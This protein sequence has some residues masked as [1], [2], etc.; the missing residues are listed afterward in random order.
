VQKIIISRTDSIGD[1]VLTMP[2]VGKLKEMIPACSIVFL[3][4]DYT[5]DIVSMSVFVDE[6][7]SWD[8]LLK[9]KSK[10]ERISALKN[11]QAD[12]IIHVFPRKEIAYLAKSAGIQNRIGTS[13]RLYHYLTCNQLVRFSR[14]RSDLHEAQ[15]NFKLLKPLGYNHTISLQEIE[16][17]YG[18]T[19]IPELSDKF[20]SLVD[21][22]KVNIILHPK[23][24]GSARE[25]GLTNFQQLIDL[26]DKAKYKVFITGTDAE[27]QLLRKHISVNKDCVDLTGKMS[28]GQLISFISKTDALVAAST[29]PLHIAAALGKLAIGIYPP[30]KPM[31][32]GRWAPIGK[33]ATYLVLKKACADCRKEGY[34]HCMEEIKPIDVQQKLEEYFEK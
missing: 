24:K 5:R 13:G 33:N 34:C 10:N 31:H 16:K 19:K 32:P 17:Y 11:T 1:V 8:Q 3:G 28:L 26:V 22:S 15:L 12:T 4:R 2:M 30:I 9:L 14:K 20:S 29:G 23:S 6:F 18:L 7:I 27:G 25:W 21:P